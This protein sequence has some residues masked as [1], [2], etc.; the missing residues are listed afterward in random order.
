[1]Q[2]CTATDSLGG[3]SNMYSIGI[4]ESNT[5]AVDNDLNTVLFV[6]RN[7][8][9]QFGGHSGQLRYD[10]STD[11]GINWNRNQGVLNPNSVNGTNAARYPNVGIYNPA[12]NTIPNNAYLSY[13]A[14]TVAATWSAHVSGVR[15]LDGTG[16]TENYNQA[17]LSYTYIPRSMCKGAPGTYW[18][19]DAVY[20][21]AIFTGYRIL[22]GVWNG[23]NDVVW[24]Q[25]AA[26]NPP[27]NTAYDG[28]NHISSFAIGFDP[29]GQKGWACMITHITQG[30]SSYS[31]YPV[32]YSTTNGGLTWSAPKQVN[33]GQ[34][35]CV[36]SIITSGNV[37]TVAF[38]MDLTVDMK[39]NPHALM[40]IGNGSN[41][42]SIY[43]TQTHH[44]YDITMEHG[45]WNA[46]DLGD[47]SGQRNTFGTAPNTLS[48][49]MAPQASRTDDGSKVFFTWSGSDI[50]N[51]P[52]APNLFGAAY[53]V[54]TRNWT[55]MKDFTSCNPAT[56]GKILFPKMAENVL[57]VTGGWELPLIYGQSSSGTD[58]AVQT[59][60]R[61]LDSLKFVQS[62]FILPQCEAPITFVGGDTVHVCQ[63]SSTPLIVSSSQDELK[64]STGSTSPI[65]SVNTGGWY[66]VSVRSGCC[67][68]R[69]SIFVVVDPLPT[70]AFNNTVNDLSV[71]LTDQ[72]TGSPT[73]WN[74]DFGDG[75]TSTMQNPAH[76]YDFPGAYTV[77]LIINNGCTDTIC[78]TVTV[79]CAIPNATFTSV[80][81]NGGLV[82]FT[83]TTTPVADSYNWNFGDGNTSALENPTH[84]Y[85][86]SGNYQVCMTITDTCGTDS[87]CSTI[88]VDV[89]AD[90]EDIFGGDFSIYPNPAQDVVH[91]IGSDLPNGEWKL[92]LHNSL[93][94]TY[95]QKT[96]VGNGFEES[97]S[98]NMLAKGIYF[99]RIQSESQTA[100][101]KIIKE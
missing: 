28:Q 73:S 94:Q 6:H 58:V 66:S 57:E 79:S 55:Q 93:G 8:D 50:V 34:F 49:D 3:A 23:T 95:W 54:T 25:N 26:L 47:V 90:L 67:I 69:D 32:F 38:D 100:D 92:I 96:Y 83:N 9:I 41:A 51:V 48:M 15:K 42:Y 61:Y 29:T 1:S 74:W 19:V 71:N 37:P 68:G 98:I 21:G 27:F 33:I 24:S 20:N 89:F 14:P 80:V 85:T 7:D 5:I 52:N 77:C 16:N 30:T 62:E 40:C 88:S 44:M 11:N 82:T 72:S 46:I 97:I 76:V 99:L 84:T 64:W 45:I 13:L 17:M 70:A 63:G 87:L 56:N 18:A 60:F 4:V 10:I 2:I 81:G 12:G 31:F 86:T 36:S 39:G 43:Y 101:Y 78:Q 35:P 75:N 65:L 59:N 53:E 22:K 91:V